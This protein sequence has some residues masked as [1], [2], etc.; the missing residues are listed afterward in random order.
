MLGKHFKF[1]IVKSLKMKIAFWFQ[2]LVQIVKTLSNKLE[3]LQT[4]HDLIV[5]HGQALQRSLA[6]LEA[7]NASKEG[8]KTPESG[9]LI[10]GVNERAT[11]FKITSNAMINA[12]TEFLELCQVSNKAQMSH[13]RYC[14]SPIL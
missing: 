7:L 6:E 2:E 10:K 5:R 3:D 14:E 8:A 1:M 12:S 13:L 11:L 9:G 4:C